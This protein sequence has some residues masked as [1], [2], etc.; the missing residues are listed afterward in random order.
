[1]FTTYFVITAVV[2][3]LQVFQYCVVSSEF[4]QNIGLKFAINTQ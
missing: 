4:C 2:L 3:N 1:M